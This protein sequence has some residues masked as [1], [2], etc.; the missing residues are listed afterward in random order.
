MDTRFSDLHREPLA[1]V[2]DIAMGC[3]APAMGRIVN[4][5]VKLGVP[6]VRLVPRQAVAALLGGTE[7]KVYSIT[8]VLEGDFDAFAML[9]FPEANG[10]ELVRLTV[11]EIAD[12]ESITEL[13]REALTE[14]GNLILNACTGTVTKLLKGEFH[15]SLPVFRASTYGDLLAPQDGG[16]LAD[17]VVVLLHI[18]FCVEQH[19]INGHL[20]FVQDIV[21]FPAWSSGSTASSPKP[22]R[23]DGMSSADRIAAAPDTSVATLLSSL[24]LGIVVLDQAANVLHWNDW[25]AK[26]AGIA[27]AE[28]CGRPL[29]ALWPSLEGG[30]V[31]AGIE[32]AL[33]LGQPT[34][35]SG[36][37]NRDL[38]PLYADPSRRP[39]GLLRL[40]ISIT[41]FTSEPHGRQCL[42]QITD[43]SAAV[44]REAALRRKAQLLRDSL[45]QQAS[46]LRQLET[47]ND[48]LDLLVRE[49]TAQLNEL[50]KYLQDVSEQEKAMLARELHDELGGLMTA[51]RIDLHSSIKLIKDSNPTVHHK[52]SR[53]LEYLDSS[54]N[55]KRSIIEGMRPTTLTHLG[56]AT[57]LR[58]LADEMSQVNGWRLELDLDEDICALPEDASLALYRVAQES[59][60]NIAKYAGAGHVSIGLF[61]SGRMIRL[62]I[63]DDGKGFNLQEIDRPRSHGLAGMRSRIEARGGRFEIS[64]T[65]GQGVAIQ[66][67]LP[68]ETA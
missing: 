15:V 57:A 28:A 17:D 20:A 42:I 63:R 5:E 67:S 61:R 34:L 49:R 51:M 60:T 40:T 39:Q 58:F 13:E 14:I 38:L 41:A 48:Q 8:Q 59:L 22:G 55:I 27:A 24:S 11:G 33:Q 10:L 26:R 46:M 30:R 66:V 47:H 23:A 25:V 6:Q 65:E 68:V 12:G 45:A 9:V 44:E 7:Q 31:Q 53:A 43:V 50:A 4:A 36:S 21:S 29:Y 32:Q 37:L 52:L 54:I 64:T 1:E 2:F 3:A 18:D 19:S 35:L 16:R 56:L 62:A